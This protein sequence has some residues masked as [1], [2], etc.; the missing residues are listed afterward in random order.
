MIIMHVQGQS[1]DEFI[2]ISPVLEISE[3]HLFYG[4]TLGQMGGYFLKQS[5]T[6]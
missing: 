6:S 1:L 4:K 3:D 5:V 2:E